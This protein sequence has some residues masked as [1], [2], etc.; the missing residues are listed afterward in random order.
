[1]SGLTREVSDN[2]DY[3]GPRTN[4]LSGV[5]QPVVSSIGS[6]ANLAAIGL[7]HHLDRFVVTSPAS[8]GAVSAGTLASTVEAILGAAYLDAG[9]TAVVQIMRTLGLGP[10]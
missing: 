6:N 8:L 10:V 7:Q 1:M 3:N 5:I 9:M 4:T 2:I